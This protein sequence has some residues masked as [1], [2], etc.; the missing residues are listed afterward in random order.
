MAGTTKMNGKLYIVTGAN[1]GI[2]KATALGLAR[3]G[4]RVVMVCRNRTAAEIAADPSSPWARDAERG[5]P[6]NAR[7]PLPAP[8]TIVTRRTARE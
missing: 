1:R 7:S 3:A 6:R 8:C 5:S 4:A 2:G